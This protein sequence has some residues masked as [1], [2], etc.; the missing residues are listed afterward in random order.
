MSSK[1]FT[2]QVRVRY[3][4]TDQM[5]FVYYG[6]YALYL[7]VARTELLRS[8]GYTYADLEKN[9]IALPV[10]SLNIQYKKAA[11]YDD[12]L[13]LKTVIVGEIGR[14]ITFQTNIFNQTEQ[15]LI[16]AHVGLVFVNSETNKVQTCPIYLQEALSN[17]Q[18]E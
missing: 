11:K 17:F 5:G 8:V 4:E 12:V 9:G 15:L 16:E 2:T 6:N 18:E 1:C 7:E 13:N 3:G 10:V 14:K